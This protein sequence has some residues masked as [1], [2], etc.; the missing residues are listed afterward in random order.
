MWAGWMFGG[1]VKGDCDVVNLSKFFFLGGGV[2]GPGKGLFMSKAFICCWKCCS[3]DVFMQMLMK[4]NLL[5]MT[6]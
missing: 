4:E 3:I 6:I 2:E 5:H 1:N